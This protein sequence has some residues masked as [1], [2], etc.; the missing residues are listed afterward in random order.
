MIESVQPFKNLP[1]TFR[2][3]RASYV[4]KSFQKPTSEVRLI[5]AGFT[6]QT[7][8][9]LYVLPFNVTKNIK[10]DVFYFK[11]NHNIL[12]SHDKLFKAKLT[13][14]DTCYVCGSKHTLKHLFVEC[15]HVHSFGNL[16]TSL[17][18][19]NNS[20]SVSLTNNDKIYGYLPEE[21]S[22]HTFNLA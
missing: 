21:H 22:F 14:S 19:D 10:L 13:D 5:D 12:Y 16:I 1:P 9:A 11:I 2:Q 18:N 3:A 15:L 20:T 6:D 7:T 8:A 17:W 4:S